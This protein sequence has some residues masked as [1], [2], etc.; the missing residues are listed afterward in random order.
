MMSPEAEKL[1]NSGKL[2]K[3][4]GEKLSKLPVGACVSHKSWGVGRVTESAVP[5]TE[6]TVQTNQGE[7]RALDVLAHASLY[8]SNADDLDKAGQESV[9]G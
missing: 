6:F 7:R 4:D 8:E 2:S 3:A 5:V 1:V 9:V